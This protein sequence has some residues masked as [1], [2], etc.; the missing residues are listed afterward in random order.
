MYLLQI[1]FIGT[2]IVLNL[3]CPGRCEACGGPSSEASALRRC[4]PLVTCG[5]DPVG[6]SRPSLITIV[7]ALRG[8][9]WSEHS[10]HPGV[11][12]GLPLP[13][14]SAPRCLLSLQVTLDLS[15]HRGIAVR[16]V[17]STEADVVSK[18][19]VSSFPSCY[20]L[21]RNG[22]VSRVPV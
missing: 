16:R 10:C 18:F 12:S 13:G 11:L 3:N 20:L 21:F 22:S 4:L 2:K 19:G 17:L 8:R 1:A 15:Q 9:A 14:G 7:C 5:G 6:D